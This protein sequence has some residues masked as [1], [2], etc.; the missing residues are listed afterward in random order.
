MSPGS[1]LLLALLAAAPGAPSGDR[2]VLVPFDNLTRAAGAREIV[3]AAVWRGLE[4]KGY[5]VVT[6]PDVDAFLRASR[7]R[8]LDSLPTSRVDE[9]LVRFKA[10]AVLTGSILSYDRKGA[11]PLVAVSLTASG[12][13]GE[14][15]WSD[16]AGL[17]ASETGGAF[18][19]G[20]TTDVALVAERL[21]ER[22]LERVPQ[23]RFGAGT[24]HASWRRGPRVYRSPELAGKPLT[25]CVL[26]L[27]NL[28]GA[29]DAG[30]TVE[31][32]IQHRL[33]RDAR[34]TAVPAADLRQAV[35]AAG[36]RA[37]ARLTLEH[38]R[39]LTATAGTTYF[40]QGSIFA[41]HAPSGARPARVEVYLRLIE[42]ESGRTLWSGLHARDGTDYESL[43]RFGV[44]R[45]TATLATHVVSELV[46]AFTD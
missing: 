14:V 6:G 45:D 25:V 1:A 3:M 27:E 10:D 18:E 43:L 39:K 41:Y 42:A 4:R 26:P 7:I 16:V 31:A 12:A 15:V 21:I 30:R 24:A 29:R 8:Y 9:L 17:T 35:L 34:V 2:V 20:R 37:P 23:L 13:E 40:L 28:S 38:L 22:Q 33:G 5:E 11:D 36:L 44:V 19:L 46:D 32:A